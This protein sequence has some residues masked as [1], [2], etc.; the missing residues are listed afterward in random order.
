MSERL[1]V[2]VDLWVT[3]ELEADSNREA[4]FRSEFDAAI[5]CRD[6]ASEPAYSNAVKTDET[7][8]VE[9]GF[10]LRKFRLFGTAFPY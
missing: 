10:I 9:T 7:R 2:Y 4:I 5:E 1:G 3:P 8:E 6:D